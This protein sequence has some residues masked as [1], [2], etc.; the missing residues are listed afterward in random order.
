MPLGQREFI[1][2]EVGTVRNPTSTNPT[3]TFTYIIKDPDNK[4]VE[5]V[6]DGST[7]TATTGGFSLLEVASDK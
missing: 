3:A 1:Y 6:L 5:Q 7:F 4:I 2:F